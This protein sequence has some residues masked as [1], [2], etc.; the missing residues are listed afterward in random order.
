MTYQNVDQDIGYD[1]RSQ[2][3]IFFIAAPRLIKG[4]H[5]PAGRRVFF[6]RFG[7][8]GYKEGH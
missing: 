8:M 2:A 6:L 4:S 7:E 5:A 1:D 3:S